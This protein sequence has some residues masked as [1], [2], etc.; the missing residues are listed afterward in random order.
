MK[1]VLASGNKGKIVEIQDLL[2]DQPITLLPQ[3]DFEIENIEETGL[4]FFENAILKARHAA[5]ATKMPAMADDSGLT[6]NALYGAPG[7]Y[8]A[9]YAGKNADDKKRIEKLLHELKLAN[10][11]DRRAAF[12]CVIALLRDENDPCPIICHG[13]WHGEILPQPRGEKGFGYDPVFFDPTKGLT[14][15]EMDIEDK[16]LI[17]HRGI[18]MNHFK[19]KIKDI[20]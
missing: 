1:I 12:H 7:V 5:H 9:R 14:A 19:E 4:T 13:V 11:Q 18:A 16:N 15:S 20:Y 3:S 2:K 8:S 17:S 10:T 6:V